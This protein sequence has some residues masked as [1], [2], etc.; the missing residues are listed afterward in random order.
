[1]LSL[2]EGSTRLV[3][4]DGLYFKC[5]FTNPTGSVKDRGFC[6]QLAK[7]KEQGFKKTVLSSS[8]NAAISAS[9]YCKIHNID[10]TVFVSKHINPQKLAAIDKNTIVVKT[11]K[12]VSSAFK[13]S[14]KSKTRLLRQ[15]TD[16]FGCFGYRTISFELIE[17]LPQID[18]VFIP[19]SSGT[20]LKGVYEGFSQFKHY[21]AIHAVQTTK[22]HPIAEK[23]DVDFKPEKQSLADA[24]VAK[25][26]PLE[27]EVINII[28]KTKGSAWMISNN[29]MRIYK[30]KL[31]LFK[32][33]CSYEGA[34]VLAAYYKAAEHGFVYKNPV[35]LLTGKYY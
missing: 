16:P 29:T 17:S 2:G 8:G 26:L 15:S 34:A 9:A 10:L 7:T 23:F 11:D 3:K 20:I 25:Y 6:F 1:M 30:R 31:D 35:C 5:E 33:N 28:K 21:P 27:D 12:P 24:I 22:I 4:K 13:E 32:L 19:V 14:Q 18:A